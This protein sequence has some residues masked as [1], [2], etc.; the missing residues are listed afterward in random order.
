MRKRLL[1]C[2]VARRV[3]ARCMLLQLCNEKLQDALADGAAAAPVAARPLK[4]KQVA[5]HAMADCTLYGPGGPGADVDTLHGA[6][7]PGADVDTLHGP[8]GPG[9]DVGTLYV[10]SCMGLAAPAATRRLAAEAA[11]HAL[12][13]G[14]GRCC[15]QRRRGA[16]VPLSPGPMREYAQSRCRR[17]RGEPSPGA[18]VTGVSPVPM[19]T[20][21]G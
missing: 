8:G 13:L 11:R 16:G 5:P 12:S 7:G 6:G 4:L 1:C 17:G 18:D 15:A 20:R 10:A 2:I 19:Q 3:D 9:A 14:R 21:Q